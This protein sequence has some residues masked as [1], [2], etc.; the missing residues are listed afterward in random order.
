VYR[1][2]LQKE[3]A[4]ESKMQADLEARKSLPTRSEP[5]AGTTGF[6]PL[7]FSQDT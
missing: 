3:H 4:I 7:F 6:A 1:H 2:I 5:A